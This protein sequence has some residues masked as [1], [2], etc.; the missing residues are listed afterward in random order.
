MLGSNTTNDSFNKYITAKFKNDPDKHILNF[1][2]LLESYK[3][4][5]PAVYLQ[6]LERIE[7]KH[8]S[9][10]RDSKAITENAQAFEILNGKYIYFSEIKIPTE[11]FVIRKVDKQRN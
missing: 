5:M 4:T 1:S 3:K 10:I 7:A 6:E 2:D 11:N 9:Y 8:K